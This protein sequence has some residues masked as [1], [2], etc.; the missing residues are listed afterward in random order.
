MITPAPSIWWS[1]EA[2]GA[3]G[4]PDEGSIGRSLLGGSCRDRNADDAGYHPLYQRR[5]GRND[6]TQ[7]GPPRGWQVEPPPD[8]AWQAPE[9]RSARIRRQGGSACQLVLQLRASGDPLRC[10]LARR[11]VLQ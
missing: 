9:R 8:P 2:R 11:T 4:K 10:T 3:S 6:R 1:K 7:G 5:K